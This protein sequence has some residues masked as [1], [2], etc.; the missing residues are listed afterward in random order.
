LSK[1]TFNS[2]DLR[3]DL[4]DNLQSLG[5]EEM[6]TIQAQT[7]P[8]VLAGRDVLA[9]GKT[10]SGK[11]VAFGLGMLSTLD[12]SRFNVQSLVLCPVRELAEQVASEIRRLAR[13]IPNVKV[14]VL[15]GGVPV[16]PQSGSLSSGVHIVVGTPGRVLDHLQR[17]TLTL[18][19]VRTL[20]LDEADRMLQMGFQESLDQIVD[21]LPTQRQTLMLSATFPDE[22]TA[23]ARRLMKAPEVIKA[24]SVHDDSSITQYF[25]CL[26]DEAQRLSALRLLILEYRPVS[27][28]VFCNTRQDVRTVAARLQGFG[29][30][31]AALHGDLDQRDREQLLTR[32]ANRSVSVLVATDVAARGIDIESL[33]VVVNFQLSRDMEVHVHRVGRT[34]RAG[35]KGLAWTFYSSSEEHRIE[36]LESLTGQKISAHSLPA[37]KALN[38]AVP[39]PP[40]VTLQIEG[41]KKQKLRPGDILGALTGEHGIEG[42]QVGK[43]KI[44]PNRTYVA[45]KREAAKSALAKLGQD[46]LKGRSF[47][48]R[49]IQ[50]H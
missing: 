22:I 39:Q 29:L 31:A 21:S 10:G 13:A 37:E 4:L 35:E 45:V 18:D 36:R 41:G 8:S 9:Q 16:G 32:F 6:T 28:L 43:I 12:V 17:E 42:S 34:G 19:H 24:D 14:L 26:D 49:K 33:D 1:E 46:K 20:V 15:C 30:S 5:Y 48:V 38:L 50:K 11:T 3:H 2:L 7:L 23:I 47:R 40:M 44:Y 25:Y 27:A